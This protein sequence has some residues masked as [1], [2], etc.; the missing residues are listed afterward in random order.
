MISRESL[1]LLGEVSRLLRKRF[2]QRAQRLGLTRPQ[3]R[4]LAYLSKN[5]GIHQAAL[6]ELLEIEPIALV[7]ILDQLVEL[8]FVERRRHPTDRRMWLLHTL[9]AVRPLLDE[10]HELGDATKDEALAGIEQARLEQT[11]AVLSEIKINLLR[12][13]ATSVAEKEQHHG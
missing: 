3:W 10:I 9:D 1:S 11:F 12:A 5:Q 8:G 4:A 7:R 2:E 6:A 13:C